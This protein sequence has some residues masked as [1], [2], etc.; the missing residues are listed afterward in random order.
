ME[1]ESSPIILYVMCKK[2]KETR[3]TKKLVIFNFRHKIR[4]DRNNDDE[5]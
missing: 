2:C 3:K 1:I 4:I 5:I